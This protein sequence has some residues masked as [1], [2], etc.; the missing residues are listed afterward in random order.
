MLV[1]SWN[2]IHFEKGFRS[3]NAENL[4]SVGQR[5]A[6]L[7]AVNIWG[8]MKKFATRPRPWLN[9][10]AQIRVVP[11]SNHSKSLM[12][13]NFKALW[14]TD[15]KFSAFKDLNFF[16]IVLK[17][18]ETGS[19]LRVSFALSKWPHFHRVYLVTICKRSSIAVYMYL[20]ILV[21][22]AMPQTRSF[23]FVRK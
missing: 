23:N 2:L 20:Q 7:L 17:V 9:W 12:A 1:A 13:G 11:G 19:I 10:S 6:K 18:Q 16:S 5:A 3:L 14:P 4:R 15:L 22:F 8:L 21:A